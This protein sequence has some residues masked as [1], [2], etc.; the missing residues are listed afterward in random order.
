M[1][2]SIH[3]GH[4]VIGPVDEP[5]DYQEYE[6]FTITGNPD[7]SR[8][9]RT[10]TRSPRGDLLR[11]VNQMAGPD[12]RP[13]EGT[14]RLFF[15]GECHGTAVRRVI[16]DRLFSY[17]WAPGEETE[18]AEFDAPPHMTIGFHPIMHEAWKMN[19]I[20]VARDDYQEVLIHTVSNTWNGRSVSHGQKLVSEAKFAGR[21]DVT[22]PAG[23]FDC[24]KFV[25]Q[26]PF[27][28][29]LH[30]WRTGPQ[31]VLVKELVAKGDKEGTLYQLAALEVV[32]VAAQA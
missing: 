14:T 10:I 32:E 6:R 26:T 8:T 30:I 13:I 24:E 3:S 23:T 2:F 31:N 11:D 18:T 15:K 27:D 5:G 12:W 1:D 22:V 20:D 17:V 29:E 9:L 25:W 16:G 21:E 7:G 4:V 19:F 28:K